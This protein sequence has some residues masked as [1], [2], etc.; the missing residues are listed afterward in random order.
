M[1]LLTTPSRTSWALVLPPLP[2]LL[3]VPGLAPCL[4]P[5]TVNVGAPPKGFTRSPGS[6]LALWEWVW[7]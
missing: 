5:A 7:S 4:P 1:T 2:A 6:S 3:P